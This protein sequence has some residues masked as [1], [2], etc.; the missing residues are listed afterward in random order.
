MGTE[1]RCTQCDLKRG[2]N[3]AGNPRDFRDCGEC[4]IPREYCIETVGYKRIIA[5]KCYACLR[6]N[7]FRPSS[8]SFFARWR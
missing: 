7:S 5:G 2:C 4:E 8:F 1:F 3:P 6:K